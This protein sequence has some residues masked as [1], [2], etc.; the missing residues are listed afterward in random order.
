MREFFEIYVKGSPRIDS[1]GIA[2]VKVGFIPVLKMYALSILEIF[3]LN[4][5]ICTIWKLIFI[6]LIICVVSTCAMKKYDASGRVNELYKK[7]SKY[8]I[9]K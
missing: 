4:Y 3:V 1:F 5:R 8:D 9:Q 6:T 2:H 7:P